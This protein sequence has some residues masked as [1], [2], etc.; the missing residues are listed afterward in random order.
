MSTG[1]KFNI[2]EERQLYRLLEGPTTEAGPSLN[3]FKE[4][5]RST[6][7]TRWHAKTMR[8]TAMSVANDATQ[9]VDK[10]NLYWTLYSIYLYIY[11]YI[12]KHKRPSMGC[13]VLYTGLE[14]STR[15]TSDGSM[16]C[17]HAND[18]APIQLCHNYFFHQSLN[19]MGQAY[20][21]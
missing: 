9:S 17:G 5:Y 19:M 3:H 18:D 14:W 15:L 1:A 2:G 16:T 13:I 20:F 12:Y 7:V 8:S 11:I 4:R 6:I 10:L 21:S